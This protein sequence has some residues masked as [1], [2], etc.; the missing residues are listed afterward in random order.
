MTTTTATPSMTELRQALLNTLSDL[1]NREN[2]M[3]IDRARAVATVA[4]VLVDSARV[5]VEF[6]KVTGGDRSQFLQP[7]EAGQLPAPTGTP[8]AHNPF[9]TSVT[10]RLK[11]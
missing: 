3:D 4:G 9:P 10:H 7:H 2:P 1:R 8:S 6:L 5:E 11:G